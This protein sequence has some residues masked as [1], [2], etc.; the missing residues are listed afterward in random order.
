MN[1]KSRHH[2][3]HSEIGQRIC[4]QNS[5]LVCWFKRTPW[6]RSTNRVS[7]RACGITVNNL[8]YPCT[9]CSV[10]LQFHVY[11]LNVHQV[12]SGQHVA[13]FIK[14]C[15]NNQCPRMIP[16]R[17]PRNNTKEYVTSM[18]RMLKSTSLTEHALQSQLKNTC[19]L[20]PFG[21][22]LTRRDYNTGEK[23][24]S[25]REE[26]QLAKCHAPTQKFVRAN[27]TSRLRMM[28]HTSSPM[29]ARGWNRF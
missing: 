26:T 8:H 20:L 4:T 5:H 15:Q 6:F 27:D 18:L 9:F 17:Q 29:T 3:K 12:A 19:G 24:A 2:L 13:H 1:L 10:D 16:E 23:T 14:W 22:L 21:Y 25:Q 7:D 11:P 28:H